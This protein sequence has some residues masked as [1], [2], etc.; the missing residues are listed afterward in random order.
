VNVS[1]KN[2]SARDGRDRLTRKAIK[3]LFVCSFGVALALSPVALANGRFPRAQRLIQSSESPD[4]MALYGTYGLVVTHDGGKT[5]N[6]VCE[7]ATGTYT[8][9]DP[10]LEI[11]PGTRLVART[12]SALVASQE[13]W[14]NYRSV[15]GNG[16]DSIA[17]ITRD[18]AE[19]NGIVALVGHYDKTAG[20][21]SRIT[22]T[23]DA[24]TTWS[25]PLDLPTVSVARGLSLDVAPSAMS[26]LY[27]TALDPMGQGTVLVSDDRG[28]HWASHAITGADSTASPFLAAVSSKNEDRIFVRTDAYVELDG[29][30][31][32]NDALLVSSDAG[33]TWSPVIT[34]HAKLFGFALSPDESTLLVGYGNPQI[35]ATNV[36]DADVGLYKAD[37]A[38]LLGDLAHAE[39]KFQKIFESS[40]TC[41]RWAAHDLFACT[42][43]SETGFEIGRAP[44]A[45]FTMATAMPFSS[46]MELKRISP[47]P[48]GAGTSAYGCYSDPVNGFPGTCGAIG[49]PCDASAPPPG[50]VSGVLTGGG[51]SSNTQGMGGQA[52]AGAPSAAGTGGASTA[53]SPAAIGTGGAAA[54]SGGVP[55]VGGEGGTPSSS[56]SSSCGVGGMGRGADGLVIAL[57]A[58]L[59]AHAARRRRRAP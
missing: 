15:F 41:L 47:L 43:V 23:K 13:S 45:S 30:D 35:S 36:D 51:G 10:L 8:G 52:T 44:D 40:I 57:L 46:V 39:G 50:T 33:A 32:A 29:I 4:V 48:C 58:A 12:E 37:V 17:D 9:E 19:P 5:W 28:A 14:C 18:P 2:A 49:A 53:G 1:T 34:R 26:R 24:G 22:Q 25:A 42:L 6:H 59:G 16:T 31:T 21:S 7:A 11:L 56:S 38:A 55:T 3:F 27:V 54:S 20:F